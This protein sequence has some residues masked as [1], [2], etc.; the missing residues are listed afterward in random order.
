MVGSAVHD[1][2][3]CNKIAYAFYKAVNPIY[4]HISNDK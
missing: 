4:P 3:V 2:K 1:K